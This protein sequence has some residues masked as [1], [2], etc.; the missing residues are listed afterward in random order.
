MDSI[1]LE[2]SNNVAVILLNNPPVNAI[3]DKEMFEIKRIFD[4]VGERKDVRAVVFSGTGDRAF[5]GGVNLKTLDDRGSPSLSW[6]MDLGRG[7]RE[8][9]WAV[10][11]CPVPV[12]GAI[13]GA[14][15][16]AG[17]ALASVCDVLVASDNASFATT[18]INVGLLGA[19]THLKMLVGRYKARELFFSGEFISS[20]ELYSMGAV[21]KVVAHEDLLATAIDLATKLSRKSPY[22]L[23]LA[24]EAMNECEHM[25]LKD[26]YHLEQ[27]YTERL[28]QYPDSDE[29]RNAYFEKREPNWAW[30]Q[31]EQ[32]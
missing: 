2:I 5:C 11:D 10:Y 19:Y 20:Q 22:A 6:S 28:R 30:D 32:K 13:N 31:P 15:V 27:H 9:C 1:K 14:A 7:F 12:I 21:S 8:A 23:R 25:P 16:G 3:S 24:K 29:A 18:E 26:A 17:L 4:E